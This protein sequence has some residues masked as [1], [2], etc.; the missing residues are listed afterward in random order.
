M[1][2]HR[3]FASVEPVAPPVDHSADTVTTRRLGDGHL[4]RQERE[5]QLQ[6]CLDRDGSLLLLKIELPVTVRREDLAKSL[7]HTKLK[8]SN[9]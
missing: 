7:T 3:R 5:N 1:P 6:P 9:I 4:V 8:L 2:F